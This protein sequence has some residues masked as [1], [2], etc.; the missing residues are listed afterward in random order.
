MPAL[1]FRVNICLNLLL[2]FS[3]FLRQTEC[4]SRKSF[5]L[6]AHNFGTRSPT[7]VRR[8]SKWPQEQGLSTDKN[9]LKRL[10]YPTFIRLFKIRLNNSSPYAACVF[11]CVSSVN[12]IAFMG[13]NTG[14][15]TLPISVTFLFLIL[16]MPHRTNILSTRI[17]RS[18]QYLG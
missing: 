9:D 5:F 14:G 3:A 2:K 12:K 6:N 10:G 8:I 1:R 13:H 7:K 18:T 4:C 17:S 16:L 11:W 15:A